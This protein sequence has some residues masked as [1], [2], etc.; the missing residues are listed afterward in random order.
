[1]WRRDAWVRSVVGLCQHR[2]M[3]ASEG[4]E[5]GVRQGARRWHSLVRRIV[6]SVLDKDDSTSVFLVAG[7]RVS[8]SPI[9]NP[10][11]AIHQAGFPVSRAGTASSIRM[12]DPGAAEREASPGIVD[13][14]PGRERVC[15]LCSSQRSA[16]MAQMPPDALKCVAVP[17][18]QFPPDATISTS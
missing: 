2:T 1:M 3:S 12:I 16:R 11:S 14:M 7:S 17:V 9:F 18:P 10:E 15:L 6:M 8:K 13:T 5:E 4:A